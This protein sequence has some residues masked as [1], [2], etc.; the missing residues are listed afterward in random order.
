MILKWVTED[1]KA[2]QEM[3]ATDK[4]ENVGKKKKKTE[5][6]WK[7]Q[8]CQII[9]SAIMQMF[10]ICAVQY[11]GVAGIIQE[12]NFYFILINLNFLHYPI[13]QPLATCSYSI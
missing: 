4:D 3:K 8:H 10:S 7:D 9:L 1:N 6:Y 11:S 13:W 5:S 12:I 2:I